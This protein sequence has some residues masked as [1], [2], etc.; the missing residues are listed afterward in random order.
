MSSIEK[1]QS[2][3]I[4]VDEISFSSLSN[5]SWPALLIFV[6]ILFA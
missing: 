3:V 5:V 4:K 6:A 1:F 2:G